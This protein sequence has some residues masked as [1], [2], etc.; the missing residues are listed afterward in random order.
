[1]FVI[2][3]SVVPATAPHMGARTQF[4]LRSV[5]GPSGLRERRRCV[6]SL[7]R[8]VPDGSD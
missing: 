7:A 6:N 2:A 4:L 5:S 3:A 8:V 1:M